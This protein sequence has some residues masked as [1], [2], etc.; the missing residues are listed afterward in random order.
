LSESDFKETEEDGT[1]LLFLPDS[2]PKVFKI[3]KNI[4]RVRRFLK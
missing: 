1:E 4:G 2:Y 3:D